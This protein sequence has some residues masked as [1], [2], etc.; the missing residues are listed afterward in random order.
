MA[1]TTTIPR[2]QWEANLRAESAAWKQWIA[3]AAAGAD[4]DVASDLAMRT[5]GPADLKDRELYAPFLR[6]LCPPGSEV[7]ILDVGAGPLT[8][9]PRTWV[10]RKILI[11]PIDPLAGDYDALLTASNITPNFRTIVGE[12]ETIAQQF[13]VD[14]FHLVFCRNTLEQC[15]DPRKA[16]EQML[17]VVKPGGC[18]LLQQEGQ[19]TDEE[20][21]RG[22]WKLEQV[23]EDPHL[24]LDGNDIDLSIE[25]AQVAMARVEKSWHWPW[26]L[27]TLK[28]A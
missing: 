17:Q 10:T 19:R 20:Q 25:F 2:P 16:I 18:V 5:N 24:L 1:Q 8:W 12:A 6:P 11:T 15:Y 14:H 21:A 23:D 28:K 13:P 4:Q 22:P 3:A 9:F 7:R 26:L 27:A